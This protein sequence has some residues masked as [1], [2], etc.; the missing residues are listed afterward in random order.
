M[1]VS[2]GITMMAPPMPSSPA[3]K[4]TPQPIATKTGISCQSTLPPQHALGYVCPLAAVHRRDRQPVAT[5]QQSHAGELALGAQ[6]GER[7]ETSLRDQ[8]HLDVEP[9]W[10]GGRCLRI[11]VRALA[12]ELRCVRI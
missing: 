6:F 11:V 12:V 3:R 5:L 7:N 2:T 4:P 10:R 9:A 1:T 8:R